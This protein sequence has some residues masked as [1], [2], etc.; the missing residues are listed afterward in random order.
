MLTV[1][2]A[3]RRGFS[4]LPSHPDLVDRLGP[5]TWKRGREVFIFWMASVAG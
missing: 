1:G 2:L 3:T 5:V 4:Q